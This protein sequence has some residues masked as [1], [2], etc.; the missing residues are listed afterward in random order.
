MHLLQASLPYFQGW[1]LVLLVRH[2]PSLPLRRLLANAFG[3]VTA[4]TG[5]QPGPIRHGV[6]KPAP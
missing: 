4:L 5:P 3:T 1:I 2:L 6:A